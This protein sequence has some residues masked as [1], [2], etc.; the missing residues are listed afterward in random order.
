[1]IEYTAHG[2]LYDGTLE[3]QID[4]GLTDAQRDVADDAHGLIL[5]D[6]GQVLRTHPTGRLESGVRV[7]LVGHD[8]LVDD[9]GVV[10]GPWIEGVGSRNRTTRFAGYGTYRRVIQAVRRRATAIA[11]RAIGRRIGGQS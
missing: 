4:V 5:A 9:G 2:P 8:F 3:R 10:Y 6:F 11:A 1:M 7:H